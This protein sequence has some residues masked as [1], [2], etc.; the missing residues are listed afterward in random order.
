M[1]LTCQ[2]DQVAEIVTGA[3]RA[4]NNRASWSAPWPSG[5]PVFTFRMMSGDAVGSLLYEQI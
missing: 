4:R 1:L 5:L 2:L 3:K